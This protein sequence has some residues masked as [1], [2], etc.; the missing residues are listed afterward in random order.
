MSWKEA[1]FF[2]KLSVFLIP[3]SAGKEMKKRE[4]KILWALSLCYFF[5]ATK[6]HFVYLF[7]ICSCW[8]H[9]QD[10]QLTKLKRESNWENLDDMMCRKLKPNFQAWGFRAIWA[11]KKKDEE[12]NVLGLWI[13]QITILLSFIKSCAQYITFLSNQTN[14]V[15]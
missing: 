14:I 15:Q 13:F 2:P 4:K 7:F 1:F 8:A 11:R 10:W 3:S 5:Y 9:I 6:A 12:R